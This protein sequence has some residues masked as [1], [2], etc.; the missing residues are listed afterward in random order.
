MEGAT[1]VS[2]TVGVSMFPGEKE[3]SDSDSGDF[4]PAGLEELEVVEEIAII[5]LE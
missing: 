5:E 2:P 1:A 3:A 4:T